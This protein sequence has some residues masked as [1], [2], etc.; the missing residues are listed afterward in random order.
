MRASLLPVLL[1]ALLCLPA[2][3]RPG[4]T[5]A[6]SFP[7]PDAG[8]M[9]AADDDLIVELDRDDGS[10][11]ERYTLRC[12]AAVEGTHPTARAACDH[13][14]GMDDP[15]APIAQDTMCTEQYDGPRTAHVTGRWGGESVDLRLARTN[16]CLISRWD[17]LGPLLPT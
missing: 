10:E 12:A 16:G 5:A 1:L 15:F 6:D 13:L 4:A 17:G 9:S 11:V 14:S 8:G 7:D 2:C 3:A